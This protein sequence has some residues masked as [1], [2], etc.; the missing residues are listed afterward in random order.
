[1]ELQAELQRA[2]DL[3]DE[4]IREDD[5]RIADIEARIAAVNEAAPGQFADLVAR[6]VAWVRD[7]IQRAWADGHST[8]FATFGAG[9]IPGELHA[10]GDEPPGSWDATVDGM[11]TGINAA[12]TLARL[13][14]HRLSDEHVVYN[15]RAFCGK[16]VAVI[17]TVP[18]E[19]TDAV[20]SSIQ[21]AL[22][23][24]DAASGGE[25]GKWCAAYLPGEEIAKRHDA[26]FPR[27]LN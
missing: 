3:R 24:A 1:M 26:V 9:G 7:R 16:L 4:H 23:A 19:A 27:V 15:P 14:G 21:T 5:E 11:R 8:V 10:L 20:V 22:A 13:A 12:M 6:D 2:K 17:W 18:N 25:R